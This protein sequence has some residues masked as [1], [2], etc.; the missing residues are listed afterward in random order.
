[1]EPVFIILGLAGIISGTILKSRKLQ[2]E[3]EEL[4]IKEMS[5][6]APHQQQ[7]VPQYLNAQIEDLKKQVANLQVIV[8][9]TDVYR[10]S[11]SS[12][13]ASLKKQIDELSRRIIELEKTRN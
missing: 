8:A 12:A 11:E 4:R 13:E 2:I 3:R 9:D 7:Q 1:M 10:L 6:L 5:M